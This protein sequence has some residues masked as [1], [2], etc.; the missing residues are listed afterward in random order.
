MDLRKGDNK[1]FIST[2]G[3]GIFSGEFQN[4]EPTFTIS[5]ETKFIEILIGEKKTIEVDYKVY[6]EFNEEVTFSLE[7]I[8]DGTTINYDPSKSFIINKDG[9]VSIEIEIDN[10]TVIG[11]YNLTLKAISASKSREINIDLNVISDDNDGD[12]I[13]N[14]DDN[15][16]ETPNPNQEDSDEDGI[17][18]AC[19]QTPFGQSTFSLQS[20]DETCRSS[21]DGKLNLSVSIN[22]PKFIVSVTSDWNYKFRFV[23]RYA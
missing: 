12:G 16:P 5:S 18:D 2:Y 20:S 17:G 14:D 8:P 23:Y 21:N 22:E 15:C 11:N 3:L 1:V 6:N 4:S 19:D 9:K 7:G 10:S 13:L